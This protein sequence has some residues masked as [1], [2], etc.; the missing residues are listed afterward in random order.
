MRECGYPAWQNIG[1]ECCGWAGVDGVY[2]VEHA[3][4]ELFHKPESTA[5]AGGESFGHGKNGKFPKAVAHE[6]DVRLSTLK[7]NTRK[8]PP[9]AELPDDEPA[10][11]ETLAKGVRPGG[12]TLDYFTAPV[13]S[14]DNVCAEMIFWKR[15]TGGQVFHA[16]AIAAGWAL[17][18]DP[19]LRTLFRNVLHRFGIEPLKSDQ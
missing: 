17:S 19:K 8:I 4:H 11:I 5:L 3:D 9:G 6:W 14:A 7:K 16:G 13:R 18:A 1:L 2:E 15:P 12:S 10:G